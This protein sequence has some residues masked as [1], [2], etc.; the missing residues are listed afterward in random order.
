MDYKNRNNTFLKMMSF[1]FHRRKNAYRFGTLYILDIYRHSG[2]SCWI[3]VERYKLN[4]HSPFV[5]RQVVNMPHLS[6]DMI[7]TC[8]TSKT[9]HPFSFPIPSYFNFLFPPPPPFNC[10]CLSGVPLIWSDPP[11]P[12]GLEVGHWSPLWK[13]PILNYKQHALKNS[14]FRSLADKLII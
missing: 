11:M 2:C 1:V 9:E 12:S 14:R 4:R 6:I 5:L 13:F 7:K 3:K 8:C 10:I